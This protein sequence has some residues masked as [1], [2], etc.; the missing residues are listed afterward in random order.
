VPDQL[1]VDPFLGTLLSYWEKKRGSRAMPRRRDI[2]PL[3]LPPAL[4]PHLE[5]VER[6]AG[7]RLRWRLIGTAVVDA[8][9]LD[10]TGRLLADVLAGEYLRFAERCHETVRTSR[11]PAYCR[12]RL[13]HGASGDIALHRL[14]VPL[15]EDDAVVSMILSALRLGSGGLGRGLPPLAARDI[16]DGIIDTL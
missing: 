5:L 16:A 9:G 10:A 13:R 4:W 6:D 12:C 8:M 14:A 15:S 11:R 3:E 1:G 7:G 2:D